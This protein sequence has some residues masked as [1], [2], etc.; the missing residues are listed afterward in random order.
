MRRPVAGAAPATWA[1]AE[2]SPSGDSKN[3]EANRRGRRS[4]APEAGALP[5]PYWMDTAG[6]HRRVRPALAPRGAATRNGGGSE[7]RAPDRRGRRVGQ[8]GPA[9][10]QGRR[11]NR[12]LLS[13]A[14]P[15]RPSPGGAAG[16]K[17][18]PDYEPRRHAWAQRLL[19]DEVATL[20][21]ETRHEALELGRAPAVE[22]DSVVHPGTGF[23]L[24]LPRHGHQRRFDLVDSRLQRCG[25]AGRTRPSG[26][27]HSGGQVHLAVCARAGCQV[28]G[29]WH[30]DL[31]NAAIEFWKITSCAGLLEKSL[32]LVRSPVG[33]C[34]AHNGR[35]DG[36]AM[37]AVVTMY[38]KRPRQGCR[39]FHQLGDSI[40]RHPV[41]AHR[42][43]HVAQPMS[44]GCLDVGSGAIH[45]HN[46]LDALR[47]QPGEGGVPHRK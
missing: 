34:F 43:M 42:Q 23:T 46:G 39:Q 38:V 41:V 18:H 9:L 19:A 12:G 4:A 20:V 21:A 29:L 36:A 5:I 10:F 14:G 15:R 37:L 8:P 7:G 11:A 17:E 3:P 16:S 25:V 28:P 26:L 27:H 47:S 24:E 33:G 32:R 45:A 6:R 40:R 30:V 22:A 13:R 2:D 31:P 35:S 1:P 44:P